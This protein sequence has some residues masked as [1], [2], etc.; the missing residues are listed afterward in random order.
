MERTARPER[1]DWRTHCLASA[2]ALDLVRDRLVR[3]RHSERGAITGHGSVKWV[4]ILT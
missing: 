3:R 2:R 1:P 4:V